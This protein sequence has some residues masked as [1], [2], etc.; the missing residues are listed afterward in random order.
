MSHQHI[1]EYIISTTK[2]SL[3]ASK[4]IPISYKIKMNHIYDM[5]IALYKAPISSAGS[6]WSYIID[7]L[8]FRLFIS[9]WWLKQPGIYGNSYQSGIQ[10]NTKCVRFGIF[11]RHENSF[12]YIIREKYRFNLNAWNIKTYLH[13]ITGYVCIRN[14]I[15]FFFF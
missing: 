14:S 8:L 15:I 5:P 12:S 4:S 1:E 3:C 9:L 2:L 11:N 10:I 6:E 7:R 13:H